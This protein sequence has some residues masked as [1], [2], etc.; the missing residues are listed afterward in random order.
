MKKTTT[1]INSILIIISLVASLVPYR[2]VSAAE[3][4]EITPSPFVEDTPSPTPEATDQATESPTPE[5]IPE[6][7]ELAE[8]PTP[9]ATL[10]NPTP[11]EIPET[12]GP[13]ESP[14]PADT[15]TLEETPS[16]VPEPTPEET[17]SPVPEATPAETPDIANTEPADTPYPE[18]DMPLLSASAS[19]ETDALPAIDMTPAEGNLLV[20]VSGSYYTET[21][22]KILKR[23]N[24]IR[25]EAC[26]EGLIDPDT[27]QALT[28]EDYVPL[29]WSSDLEAIAR[30]RALEACVYQSHTRPN[31]K[32]CFSVSTENGEQ[33][34]AE[35]LAWNYDGLMKG[36]EQWYSEKTDYVK[37]TGKVTG[38][39][40]SIISTKHKYVAVGA[41]R[42]SSGGWYAVA[43]EFSYK[44]S[45]DEGK[46]SEAGK[47]THYLECSKIR[48][49]AW[50]E[51]I[52]PYLEEGSS[53]QCSLKATVS[54]SAYTTVTE[55]GPVKAGGIWSSSNTEVAVVDFAGMVTAVSP[56][57]TTITVEAGGQ[58]L[59]FTL[60]VYEKGNA[61]IQIT[62]PTKTTYKINEKLDIKGAKVKDLVTGKEEVI[63]DKMISGFSSANA[64]ISTVTV[65]YNDF[66]KTFDTLI[67]DTPGLNA[68][69]GQKLSELTLPGS[70]F[71]YYEWLADPETVLNVAGYC[72][73]GMRFVPYD[74]DH[75][76]VL[77]DL[78]AEISV[79]CDLS[80]GTGVTL[81]ETAFIYDGNAQRPEPVIIKGSAILQEGKDYQLT[82][83]DNI[84]AGT[85]TVII[86][87]IGYY[88]GSTAR[89][90]TIEKAKLLIRPE[91]VNLRLDDPVPA[92]F[93][94]QVIGLI[95]S[96][97]LVKEPAVTCNVKST[98]VTGSYAIEARDA[99]AGS[100]YEIVYE[101]ATLTVAESLLFHTVTFDTLGHGT[102]PPA[103]IGVAKG[104]TIEEPESPAADGYVFGGWYQDRSGT[105]A[106]DFEKDTVQ[107]DVTLYA[108]WFLA[109][110]HSGIRIQEIEDL[111]YTGS[112]WKPAVAVYDG[113]ILL[114]QGK[115]YTVTYKNNTSANAEG[116]R[117]VGS[118]TGSDFDDT[119]PYVTI[120]GKGNYK[121][122]ISL[123]FN[124][125][126]RQIGDERGDAAPGVKLKYTEQNV[127]NPKKAISPFTSLS[128]KKSLKK[129]RDYTLTLLTVKSFDASGGSFEEGTVLE[130]AVVPAGCIGTFR[131]V[132]T[133]TGN[134]EG[135]ITKLIQVSEK[136]SMMQYAVI[137]LGRNIKSVPYSGKAVTLTPAFYDSV[138]KKYYRIAGG[139][140]TEETVNAADIYT[141]RCGNKSLVYGRDY[142]VSYQNNE[143]VGTAALVITGKGSYSGSKSV[144]FQITGNAF[145]SNTVT[146]E[147][148]KDLGYT[149]KALTQNDV[150]LTFL[151]GQEGEKELICGKDYTISYKNNREK[152]TATMTFCGNPGAGYAGSFSKTFKILAADIED[153][154]QVI[155]DPGMDTIS[156]PYEKAGVRP[157]DKVKLISACGMT[158]KE[159]RDYTVTVRN[160]KS[161]A[162]AN[163]GKAPVLLIKG[164]GNY[165]GSFEVPF[166]ITSG[167]LDSSNISV[168]V[169]PVMYD[170][171]KNGS[172]VYKPSVKVLDGKS[173]LKAGSD[174]TIVWEKNTRADYDEYLNRLEESGGNTEACKEYA[175]KVIIKATETGNYRDSGALEKVIPV[176]LN[177]FSGS[178]L[179]V[180]VEPAVYTG[181]QVTPAVT[182]C[183]GDKK[184]TEA[185]DYTVSYG[186]NVAS[187]KNKGTLTVTGVG[188]YYGGSVTVKFT[189]ESRAMK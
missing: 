89:S 66:T 118:G 93:A 141:V 14:E 81:R 103:Y 189:I 3:I 24:Q 65:T 152:G 6:F 18:E 133:G 143:G 55:T 105:K 134:Y 109:K 37:R 186:K 176:Y 108:R 97:R 111:T 8:S 79:Y 71:G 7:P 106:W 135:S 74:T 177:K 125:L 138:Q 59:S 27:N 98:D 50:A 146:V 153:R 130:N 137:T 162:Q 86:T 84:H 67:V 104:R 13:T 150:T 83:R 122:S 30:L 112:A 91:D 126:P 5:T 139:E 156:V 94:Y 46:C 29:K 169:S 2:A 85:A 73:Y 184:L 34:W 12:P 43:Q 69:W 182:V 40:E 155:R 120:T 36:I 15:P 144:S 116:K 9:A 42:L 174:Y 57:E 181:G 100:D 78:K 82:Y 154:Q 165:T 20:G 171:R 166:T 22:D 95:E 188:P 140:V 185:V 16:V 49:L 163:D 64:G 23:L 160:N 4:A 121:E 117:K 35:N 114:R 149:G 26:S 148:I 158:L 80:E 128:D 88:K 31:G 113:D 159:G 61:P 63:T 72:Q 39:Y 44:S 183:Y 45:M 54:Y 21:A 164:K 77:S 53:R 175:P 25:Y 180:V 107:S 172:Y 110:E 92:Q 187:G 151:K 70:E 127:A 147:G 132:I 28:V 124:I 99:D 136:T 76:Q 170:S 52:V 101:K 41:Y 179:S 178:N 10:E 131:L 87:G 68:D 32:R 33:S 38:H 17:M 96:D 102:E 75:F 123:N 168:V 119:L 19:Y 51:K 157:T 145:K 90:F 62:P 1:R 167:K 11:E 129:N 48:K 47:G 58:K 56:G 142:T 115:D 161:V 60:L 173:V